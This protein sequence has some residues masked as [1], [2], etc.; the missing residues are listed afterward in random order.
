MSEERIE[1]ITLRLS[2]EAQKKL[3]DIAKRFPGKDGRLYNDEVVINCVLSGLSPEEVCNAIP[4]MKKK[5]M[6]RRG[7]RGGI[8]FVCPKC[9]H[10]SQSFQEKD[11][12]D[13][14]CQAT[15]E[16]PWGDMKWFDEV[17]T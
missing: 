14:L 1:K 6:S 4:G 12:H 17:R 15:V 3:L 13:V 5:R 16:N 11:E 10:V 9:G 7:D 8:L 2:I